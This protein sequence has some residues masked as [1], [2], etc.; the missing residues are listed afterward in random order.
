VCVEIVLYT[1]VGTARYR[2]WLEACTV[3]GDRTIYSCRESKISVLFRR[4]N[5]V[6]GDRTVYSCRD[7]KISVLVRRMNCVCGNRTVYSCRDSKISVLVRN[8]H[9]VLLALLG[10]H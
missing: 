10:D 8:V 1:A 2:Y 3:C 5:C 6:C 7:S 9:F 4:M